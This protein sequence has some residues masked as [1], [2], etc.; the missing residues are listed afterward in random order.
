[1]NV[2]SSACERMQRRSRNGGLSKSFSH[3]I[4]GVLN[5]EFP[6]PPRPPSRRRKSFSETIATS[7]GSSVVR[8]APPTYHC[9]ES[10]SLS[11]V[12][13]RRSLTLVP[14]PPPPPQRSKRNKPTTAPTIAPPSSPISPSKKSSS[15]PTRSRSFYDRE[16]GMREPHSNVTVTAAV[17]TS[18]SR[19]LL[20]PRDRL[21]T[22]AAGDQ[23]TATITTTKVTNTKA[24]LT[25]VVSIRCQPAHTTFS[26][27]LTNDADN[28]TN[29]SRPKSPYFDNDK[30]TKGAH[31]ERSHDGDVASVIYSPTLMSETSHLETSDDLLSYLKTNA[32]Q[33]SLVLASAPL[34]RPKP[35]WDKAKMNE[36]HYESS[37]DRAIQS[38]MSESESPLETLEDVISRLKTEAEQR[39]LHVSAPST[40]RP[41]SP[42]FDARKT[43]KETHSSE[44]ES[45]LEKLQNALL[46]LKTISQGSS[47]ASN[48]PSLT[49][50]MDRRSS[51]IVSSSC[52]IQDVVG[53]NATQQGT[54]T[55]TGKSRTRKSKFLKSKNSGLLGSEYSSFKSNDHLPNNCSQEESNDNGNDSNS[56]NN[57]LLLCSKSDTPTPLLCEDIGSSFSSRFTVSS[58]NSNSEEKGE[59]FQKRSS[60]SASAITKIRRSNRTRHNDL[61]FRKSESDLGGLKY[62]SLK[63]TIPNYSLDTL[64]LCGEIDSSFGSP[65]TF[66]SVE[67]EAFETHRSS[68]SAS[69]VN[70]NIGFCRSETALVVVPKEEGHSNKKRSTSAK[71]DSSTIASIPNANRT[72]YMAA[73]N[74]N[75]A[76]TGVPRNNCSPEINNQVQ[77]N[78]RTRSFEELVTICGVQQ[79]SRLKAQG[80]FNARTKRTPP[81]MYVSQLTA[82]SNNGKNTEDGIHSLAQLKEAV[83][84]ITG[85]CDLPSMTS[86][87][88][89]S[90]S[91]N[92]NCSIPGTIYSNNTN[93]DYH[94]SPMKTTEIARPNT[95]RSDNLYRTITRR[96]QRQ[97]KDRRHPL[98][99]LAASTLSTPSSPDIATPVSSPKRSENKPRRSNSKN[100]NKSRKSKSK[101]KKSSKNNDHKSESSDASLNTYL[102][103]DP[104]TG[105]CKYHTE[106]CMAVKDEGSSVNATIVGGWKIVRSTCPKCVYQY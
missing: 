7:S 58:S 23:Q 19:S 82:C 90:D 48:S 31:S 35:P 18:P 15:R 39:I 77:V 95:P 38:P 32:D 25:R 62:S 79:R 28:T 50:S 9:D 57:N 20:S 76:N 10:S 66:T 52:R 3:D 40:P 93:D 60:S 100:S 55:V 54:M 102:P 94:L 6:P 63:P 33:K 103:F 74:P 41:R 91:S 45:P 65:T 8:W 51:P 43:M 70:S 80:Q 30:S 99:H 105:R 75:N 17:A 44:S 68:S 11:S 53:N 106:V 2:S 71:Q 5:R 37:H 92:S 42:Y 56:G 21:S 86:S 87:L 16:D 89:G 12:A 104:L 26:Q 98:P 29:T 4:N 36:A 81:P 13:F 96:R 14:S 88:S 34:S 27:D 73:A 85:N 72:S 84:R 97:K 101:N 67:K 1:M 69:T 61:Q 46:R 24:R 49:A 47:S 78:T 64:L 22:S 83:M 59:A